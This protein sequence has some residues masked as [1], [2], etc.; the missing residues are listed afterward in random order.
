[1]LSTKPSHRSYLDLVSSEVTSEKRPGRV[2]KKEVSLLFGICGRRL[3]LTLSIGCRGVPG[4]C[5]C[6]QANQGCHDRVRVYG[7]SYLLR[8]DPP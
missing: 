5:C 4:R 2:T 1:M 6:T 7:S 3:Y 8:G